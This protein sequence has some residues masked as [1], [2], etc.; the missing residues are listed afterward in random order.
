MDEKMTYRRTEDGIEVLTGRAFVAYLCMG[1]SG[2][3]V[4]SVTGEWREGADELIAV[5]ETAEEADK[6]IDEYMARG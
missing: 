2:F 3:N 5:C 6:A 1:G 4:V